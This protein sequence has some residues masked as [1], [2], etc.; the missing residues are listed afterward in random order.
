MSSTTTDDSN[1]DVVNAITKDTKVTLWA[2]VFCAIGLFTAYVKADSRLRVM[3]N[4][5]VS[6]QLEVK[7]LTTLFE[8]A[9]SDR[10]TQTEM[11]Y[12][13]LLFK[14]KNPEIQVPPV[15]PPASAR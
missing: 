10:W 4:K 9:A 1:R 11:Y 5:L 3:E 2:A 15:P 12:W 14:E 13:H 8:Q 6:L 7:N